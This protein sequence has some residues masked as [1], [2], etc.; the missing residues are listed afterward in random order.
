[1]ATGDANG[2]CGTN[3]PGTVTSTGNCLSIWFYASSSV[4]D[5]GWAASISCGSTTL[6][7]AEC[8]PNENRENHPS[9]EGDLTPTLNFPNSTLSPTDNAIVANEANN[10][11]KWDAD[12]DNNIDYYVI[13]DATRAADGEEFV[14]VGY[15]SGNSK[16]YCLDNDKFYYGDPSTACGSG[17][18][19]SKV[20]GLSLI[21]I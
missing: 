21:H 5:I 18:N 4:N 15:P 11:L 2:Y 9:F 7:S 13:S 1:M 14:Y 19:L 17:G 6:P 16:N 3:S 10:W 12:S 20:Q 8:C